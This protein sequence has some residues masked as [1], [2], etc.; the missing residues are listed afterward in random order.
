MALLR[1]PAGPLAGSRYLPL[2]YTSPKRVDTRP[3]WDLRHPA[4]NVAASL[5]A[6]PCP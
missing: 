4:T 6:L 5:A 1:F 3:P 2:R